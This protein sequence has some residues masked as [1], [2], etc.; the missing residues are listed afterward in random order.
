MKAFF[1]Q[2]TSVAVLFPTEAK[3]F[4]FKNHCKKINTPKKNK[5]KRKYIH[6]SA[7]SIEK[8][9]LPKLRYVDK[10]TPVVCREVML[11]SG[12]FL[13]SNGCACVLEHGLLRWI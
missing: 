11:S 7:V 1:K 5:D 3:N 9:K 6:T 12:M 4:V 10:S 8:N 13:Y 2:V